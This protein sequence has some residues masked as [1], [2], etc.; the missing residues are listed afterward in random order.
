[1]IPAWSTLMVV[2]VVVVVVAGDMAELSD[3]D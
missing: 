1:M 3:C 2:V